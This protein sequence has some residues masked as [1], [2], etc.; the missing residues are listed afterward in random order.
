MKT[1]RKIKPS[2]LWSAALGGFALF[3]GAVHSAPFLYSSG[4]LVLSFRQSGNAS[5]YVVNLGKATNYNALPPGTSISITNLAPSQL[6]QA[7][8]VLNGIKW[9]VAGANRPPVDPAFPIQTIWVTA[10]RTSPNSPATAWLRKG[11][12]LQGNTASQIDA[13]GLNGAQ[14]SSLLP[15]GPGNTATGVVI[16]VNN[17]FTIGPVIGAAGNYGNFQGNVETVT[18]EDFDALPDSVS[19]ADLFELIPGTSAAGT[20]NTPGRLLGTFELKANGTLTFS[21]ASATPTRPV[22]SAIQRSGDTTTLSFSTVAGAQY[23]LRT[24][25]TA[26]LSAPVSGWSTGASVTGDGGVLSL[27]DTSSS[28]T[29]FYVIEV[30]P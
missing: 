5:D 28:P 1:S 23:Q 20:V 19:R 26:G 16:P 4:D 12:S 3:T 27:K 30:K 15:G 9:A 13:V 2:R 25:D 17:N 24:T 21:T 18:P 22:I 8:P 7:F 29:R 10:P 6:A 14:A 11:Q